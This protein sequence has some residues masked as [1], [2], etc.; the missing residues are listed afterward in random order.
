LHQ[1][2]D[3]LELN[4][5][6]KEQTCVDITQE[7]TRQYKGMQDELYAQMRKLEDTISSL[8]SKLANADAAQ[9]KV[10]RDKD[11]IIRTKN[12][13]ISELKMKMDDMADEFSHMLKVFETYS[14]K[15][16]LLDLGNA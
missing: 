13:E 3:K 10:A 2:V 7:M 1:L 8:R 12:N 6:Q 5:R 4:N 9:D 14:L 15:I 11:E 16:W